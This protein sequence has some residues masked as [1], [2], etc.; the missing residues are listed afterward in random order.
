MTPAGVGCAPEAINSCHKFILLRNGNSR[1]YFP[2][3]YKSWSMQIYNHSRVV[4]IFDARVEPESARGVT[5]LVHAVVQ[6]MRVMLVFRILLACVLSR[7]V[8]SG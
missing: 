3:F 4:D 5:E 7:P 8:H 2:Y 6:A 1:Y